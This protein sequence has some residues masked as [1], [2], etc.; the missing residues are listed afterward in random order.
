LNGDRPLSS[1]GEKKKA[2]REIPLYKDIAKKEKGKKGA[3]GFDEV[4]KARAFGGE[5]G[6]EFEWLGGPENKRKEEERGSPTVKPLGVLCLA[7]GH[8]RDGR[9]RTGAV[10]EEEGP[11]GE[12][13]V[14]RFGN[15]KMGGG[16]KRKKAS[17]K[18]GGESRKK[19]RVF[20]VRTGVGRGHEQDF[21]GGGRDGRGR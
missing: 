15:E 10:G 21:G 14:R 20:S 19:I 17:L 18:G 7:E 11:G 16:R 4:G 8:E 1:E 9:R 6:R 2:R 3:R 12:R 5:T 13:A